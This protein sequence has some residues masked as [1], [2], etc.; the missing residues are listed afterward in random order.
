MGFCCLISFPFYRI[1]MNLS[2]FLILKVFEFI[3]KQEDTKQTELAAKVAEFK[4]MQ[5]Q[6]ETVS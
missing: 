5:A 6:H 1:L 4:Q 2:S 3:K